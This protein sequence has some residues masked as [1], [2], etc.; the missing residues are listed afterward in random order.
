MKNVKYIK[1]KENRIIVFPE[2]FQHS[3]F[4]HFDPITAGFI[5]FGLNLKK[6]LV[7]N[8]S[9]ESVSLGIKSAEIDTMLATMQILDI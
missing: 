4:R 2:F 6:E 3:D 1:T 8:C 9:G 5:S 7:C